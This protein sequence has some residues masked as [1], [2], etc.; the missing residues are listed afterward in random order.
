MPQQK[1][2]TK[3]TKD[4]IRN[5][6]NSIYNFNRKIDRLRAKGV[7][8]ILPAKMDYKSAK[9]EIVSRR[10]LNRQ[11]KNIKEFTSNRN[12][13]IT[14][15]EG[16]RMTDWQA[17]TIK[18]LQKNAI[19]DVERRLEGVKRDYPIEKTLIK[20]PLQISLETSMESL[21]RVAGR[22]TQ[23]LTQFMSRL[24][25]QGRIDRQLSREENFQYQYIK[26]IKDKYSE[27]PGFDEFIK[28]LESFTPHEFYEQI[29]DQELPKDLKYLYDPRNQF[30]QNQ[31][32]MFQMIWGNDRDY[33][34][35]VNFS[36]EELQDLGVKRL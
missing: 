4:E 7:D 9:N 30:T 25:K 32:T 24:Y 31:F 12:L 2:R 22:T 3:F 8:Y 29:R 13:R 34:T 26:N 19:K 15:F 1:R 14:T 10:E 20:T 27:F 5:L 11:I 23:N 16:Y 21:K 28:H 36:Q 17:K 18:Y 35:Y 6:R 33:N